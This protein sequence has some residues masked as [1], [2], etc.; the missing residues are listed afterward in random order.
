[1]GI[2]RT[3]AINPTKRKGLAAISWYS[4]TGAQ[5]VGEF[6]DDKDEQ[7]TVE[8]KDAAFERAALHGRGLYDRLNTTDH[9]EHSGRHQRRK[10][11]P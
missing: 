8:Y 9:Y 1:M 5:R 2:C 10:A 11:S 7:D 4:S 3:V 6:G